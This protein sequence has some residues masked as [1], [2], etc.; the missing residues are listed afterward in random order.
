MNKRELRKKYKTL[1]QTLDEDQIENL[2]LDIANQLLKLDIWNYSFYHIF[3]SIAKHKEINTEY[4]LNILSGKDKHTVIAKSNF[5]DSSMSHFLLSDD[6]KLN[7]NNWGIPE[8]QNGIPIDDKMIDVV[9]M[10]LLAFDLKGNRVGYG[11]GFYDRFLSRCK[12][13]TLKIG[14]SFYEA[15]DLISDAS[16]DDIPLDYCVTPTKTYAFNNTT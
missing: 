7:V 5:E 16:K 6:T 2:S 8:P 12:L 15:E 1:R 14:L 10:P 11:K 9:F 4:I 3:L 13:E